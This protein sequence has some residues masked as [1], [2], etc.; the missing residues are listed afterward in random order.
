MPQETNLNVAPYFDDFSPDSNYYKVL[1][2]P[3]FPVQARELNTLQSILQNQ[4]EDVGNHFFKEG[5]KVIPGDLIYKNNFTCIQIQSE[6]LGIPVSL[7]VDQLVGKTITGTSS[8]VT[9]T[10]VTYLTDEQSERG[11]YT[12]YVNYINSS[13]DAS[14]SVF[15]DGEV[16]TVGSEITFATTFIP[17]GEGFATTVPQN[18]SATGSAFI[19]NA[20]IYFLRGTFV[21]V[22]QQI[23][24]IDQY[25]N[26][27]SARIGLNVVEEIITPDDDPSLNDNAQ[28]FNNFTA[29]GADRFK[30]TAVLAKK[31]LNEFDVENFVQLAEVQGGVLRLL[32]EN[33]DYNYLAQE[34]ARRTY[35]ESGH[36]YVKDF[37]TTVRDSLNN[38]QGN[39]GIYN[40]GQTTYQGN[41][42]SD[43]LMVYKVSPG[44]A[45]V[46]GYEVS[47]LGPSLIDAQ[48]P[49]T[50]KLIKNQ[51][52]NFGFGPTFEVNNVA[53]SP[54]LGFNT[55]N[56]LS[57]RDQRVGVS[58]FVAAGKEIG[59]A[60][61]YDFSLESGSY[62]STFPKLNR[63]DLSLFDIV[64]DTELT[65]NENVTLNIPT[66]VRG[67]SSGATGFLKTSVSAGT[68]LT[69]TE[70]EGQ[71]FPG[72]NLIFNG[73]L[74]N[75]RFV[76]NINEF[77][78][79]DV[80]SVFGQVGGAA[81][82]S[83]DTSLKS[84][85]SFGNAQIT[86]ESI[87]VSTVSVPSDPGISFV[88]VV[89]TGDVVQFSR[90]GQIIV[91]YARV[92]GVAR[93]NFQVSGVT[94]VT[95][96]CDGGLPTTLENVS[97]LR[98][99]TTP[100]KNNS[101]G[102][103][104]SGNEALF[105]C[106][107]RNNV[108]SVNLQDSDIIIRKQYDVNIT[109]NSTQTIASGTNQVFLPFD[110]ERY[111]LIRSDGDTEV[112]TEDKLTFSNGSQN[113][114]I[115][116]LGTNDIDA[117]LITTVRKS[118][119]SS[120]TKLKR[121]SENLIIDKSS[122]SAS[123]IG[124]T[125][126]NDG[127]T[128]G[129]YPFGTRV[130][131]SIICL[132]HPDLY[133][134]YGVYESE[135]T[136][137]PVSPSMTLAS[138]DGPTATTDDLI[139]GDTI[140]GNISGAQAYYLTKNNQVDVG[141]AY[142]NQEVFANGEVVTFKNSG[143][144]AVATNIRSGS[145]NITRSFSFDGGQKVDYYDYSTL[146]RREQAQ[147]PSRKLRVYYG[148][149]YY[150]PSD[151]GDITTV[152][153]Y[154]LFDYGT[155]IAVTNGWRHQDIVD[156]RPRVASYAVTQNSRSPFEFDGRSFDLQNGGNLHSAQYILASDES[157]TL[158]FAYYLGRIDRIYVDTQR[159]ISV[160]SGT[161]DDQP[162]LP[163]DITGQ[164]NIA[165][166]YLPPYLYDTANANVTFIQHKR[167]Q[168]TD[169]SNLEKRIK[170]IE[171]YTSLNMLEQETV[172][173]FVQDAN[174]LNKFKSGV[175][176][177]NFSTLE[178]QDNKLGVR[179]SVDTNKNLLRPSHYTTAFNLELATNTITGIGT[180]TLTNA[181]SRFADI[182]GTNIKRSGQIVT[183]DYDDEVYFRQPYATRTESVTPFVVREWV[184]RMRLEPDT[185]IWVET[186]RLETRNIESE[187]TFDAMA[188]F[189]G[190]EITTAEDGSRVGVSPVVWNSWETTG[191]NIDI[192]FDADTNTEI[193]ENIENVRTTGGVRDL[194]NRWWG[195]DWT[196]VET[197]TRTA[198]TTTTVSVDGQTT[199]DQ[200][201]RGDQRTITEFINTESLGDRIVSR[202]VI[203]FQRVRNIEV[204]STS[205]KPFT[206]MYAF[207][208][209]VDVN[210]FMIPKLIEIQMT[211]GTFQIGETVQG[212]MNNDGIELLAIGTSPRIDFRVANPNHKYGPYNN[213]SDV[214]D[215]NP[216]D[217]EA[218]PETQYTQSSSI[219]NVDTFS[220][221]SE[222]FTN[223]RGWIREGMILT[224][225]TSG[226]QA[227]VTQV[228][229]VTDRVG[230]LQCCFQV[231]DSSIST[232]PAF[233]TGRN[234]FR[235][236]SSAINTQVPG[237]VS[238]SSE[239]TF[240]SQGDL[241]TTQEVTLSVRNSRVNTQT[242]T[243]ERTFNAGEITA[244]DFSV[245]AVGDAGS[246]E[247]ITT[248]TE[249]WFDPLAQ[250]F[251]VPDETGVF[252]SKI[253]LFF[254]EI[255]PDGIPVVLQL[256][257]TQLG[258]PTETFL[259]FSQVII[260]PSD[261]TVTDDGTVAT[262]IEFEAPVYLNPETDYA[263][264]LFSVSP[265]Y[266]V[267][268]SRL[269]E[270]DVS[271]LGPESG[272]VLVT[273]QPTLG[274]L[275][276][277]QNASVWTP[278]Q[279]EDLKYTLYRANFVSTG[280]VSFVNPDLTENLARIPDKGINVNSR[281]IRVGLGTTV[282]DSNLEFGNT[283][284]Q[285]QTDGASGTLVALAGSATGDLSVTNAGVGYTPSA[286]QL[287]YTG[288]ALTAVTGYGINATANITI[289]SGVAIAATIVAGGEGY[290][291]GD[292]LTPIEV[293][294]QNLGSNIQVSIS[295]V[296]GQNQL[297]LTDVQGTFQVSGTKNVRFTTSAGVSTELNFSIGGQVMIDRV[298]EVV[299]GND[300]KIFQRNHGMY[301]DVNR[302]TLSD[303]KSDVPP[304]TLDGDFSNTATT[305]VQISDGSKFGTF[306]N[307]GIANT[308]PGFVKVGEEIISYTGIDANT[309]T[310]VT[311]GVNNTVVSSHASG[312]LV[313]K[314]ELDG[315][316]LLRINRQHE[317]SDYDGTDPITLDT[318]DVTVNMGAGSDRTNR[319]PGNL[320]GFP[321][322]Y[323]NTDT[324]AGG[325]NVSGSYNLLYTQMVP[326]IN[327]ITPPG[328]N[329]INSIRTIS[330]TSVS[331]TEA[332]FIDQGFKNFVLYQ[333][334]YFDSPRM[335]ASR[336][337]ENLLLNGDVFVGSKSI[338]TIHD[339]S[340]RDSRISPVIDIDNASIIFTNNRVNQPVS[341]YASDSRVN[342]VAGDPNR[343][344]YVTKNITLEN[345]ATSLSILLDAYVSDQNDIRA[346]FALNQ[347]DNL[348]D[349]VFV[350]F[351]GYDN[352]DP[353]G[354][355]IDTKNNSGRPDIFVPKID[356]YTSTPTPQLFKEYKFTIDEKVSFKSFR[357]KIVGTSTNQA[358]VPQ[359]KR[360]RT[361]SFA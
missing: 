309:L 40:E 92:A 16:L 207:F 178:P 247:N 185:D 159:N 131:D 266:R 57:L 268:I 100:F 179:N 324:Q 78:I 231:P 316:S 43:D 321:A 180:T 7:Y 221:A 171:Y 79:S 158:D 153:S 284:F 21:D 75:S 61:I 50:T 301:S 29:P 112:L 294:T 333:N 137:D 336:L 10:V 291:I 123:G 170:N 204:T 327:T 14:T 155:E 67:D 149:A 355:I 47:I 233:E 87:G 217:R 95:G 96:V 89:S 30:I 259:P 194:G 20:G 237:N 331:G 93:T 71:F 91:N 51:A 187:G 1:F 257:T 262:Q 83:A 22:S 340:T 164:L 18:S 358:V 300:L 184:G 297:E 175:F 90:S 162:R 310:G 74:D 230:T 337:N 33:T 145:P 275:F 357:I 37:V 23:L 330:G 335:V 177:D 39:K 151:S 349:V 144:N 208:D 70:T 250:T 281:T 140:I 129:N 224:G 2:K 242:L 256:R 315:V 228:R 120:K 48:K 359:I 82:F 25:N 339:L 260:D 130:Q 107:S 356:Q 136:S 239:E 65:V 280:S 108:E 44:K 41:V 128:H 287:T 223:F 319:A 195:R 277:S 341:D 118:K 215:T 318:Y 210:N 285:N 353:S 199:L 252:I 72:E 254:S 6:F 121:V 69:V 103:N 307:L 200:N 323:F 141:L 63:W 166:I 267:W 196:N 139:I 206:R 229:L 304:T 4:I 68:A 197:I 147:T 104:P 191:V 94:T 138:L 347:G 192:G 361:I 203:H 85:L 209:G 346:F 88:G 272:Q 244:D 160:V 115:N 345:P 325:P 270:V 292:V 299:S 360:L 295:S 232:N 45:Y 3:G 261:I 80:Q 222:D 243:E 193:S 312:E 350:P 53:G 273:Q 148:R 86:G 62:D 296:F 5:A 55:T 263:I 157:M 135:D 212:R 258:T 60:R 245:V 255:D 352:L 202:E 188:S 97:N 269:G 59:R 15:S 134:L 143:V 113:L 52:V 13:T 122:N 286:S 198:T 56:T 305:F 190:A 126:L 220:L 8:G 234:V 64:T 328:T 251:Q 213:P 124:S 241:E 142:I 119:V 58:S 66:F 111:T 348:D 114:Q 313:Y 165:N 320:E 150:D 24:I 182:L 235:L 105:T 127:L 344:I 214:Y 77:N 168:M 36:Y 152:N 102:G 322:L 106:L 31:D 314:Y 76:N 240:F 125:T 265:N 116:N 248:G 189:L 54:T 238:S 274:S 289:S 146:V 311:R 174:G 110:E 342:T 81:T 226:A 167:Y 99:L 227:T 38:G 186:N 109:N 354:A 19:L 308:N 343:F 132:N 11:N 42:P 306:E 317:L 338:Q 332:S 35:D 176:V 181:D 290:K 101:G 156:A 249:R 288:V 253:D 211:S 264:V 161:P 17:A 32:N 218:I 283:V 27:P 172:N 34:L 225:Q 205:L 276:K 169:I 334:V 216:Y 201:R 279:Y 236:T 326:K 84:S 303:V 73:T 282:A 302:L 28:G 154:N 246:E 173:L 271:T 163:Q 98:L 9:A 219:I 293:G 351:P 278:S 12:L 298:S 133:V 49:R 117:K 46:K 26:R 183:L 329:L